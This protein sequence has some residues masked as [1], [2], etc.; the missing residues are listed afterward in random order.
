MQK[1]KTKKKKNCLYNVRDN[2]GGEYYM[3]CYIRKISVGN[4]MFTVIS[5]IQ[6]FNIKKIIRCPICGKE[7]I[8]Y[9]QKAYYEILSIEPSDSLDDVNTVYISGNVF[10]ILDSNY[11]SYML[12]DEK[13]I[14]TIIV[15]SKEEAKHRLF[16]RTDYNM[17]IVGHLIKKIQKEKIICECGNSLDYETAIYNIYEKKSHIKTNFMD[18]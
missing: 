17:I 15:N 2:K 9:T 10:S 11:Y 4:Q 5:H 18:C 7:H 13:N 14:Y 6:F 8:Y 16:L 3:N 12:K 1:I